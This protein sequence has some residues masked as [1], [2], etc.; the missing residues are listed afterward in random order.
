MIESGYKFITKVCNIPQS[1]RAFSKI[2]GESGV[3]GGFAGIAIFR[4]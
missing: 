4:I 2:E 3:K 1:G